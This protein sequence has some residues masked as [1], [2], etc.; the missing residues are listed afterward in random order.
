MSGGGW[1]WGWRFDDWRRRGRELRAA[2]PDGAPW[3]DRVVVLAYATATGLAVVGFTLWSE[4]AS[5]GF[6]TLRQVE[7]YTAYLAL[8]WTP[9]L[10]VGVL[11]WT[12][13]WVPSAVGSGI[14]QVVGARH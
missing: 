13:P 14:P 11:W 7:P 9:A 1:A 4:A 3:L 6:D 12:Q 10:T 8:L 5:H 2:L